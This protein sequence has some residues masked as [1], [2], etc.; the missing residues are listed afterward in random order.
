[1]SNPADMHAD[2]V[3]AQ[4][5]FVMPQKTKTAKVK[6]KAGGE[7]SYKYAD[8]SDVI[9]SIRAILAENGFAFVQSVSSENGL[10]GVQTRLLH[11]SGESIEGAVLFLPAG[12]TP[13]EAGAAITYARRYSLTALLGIAAD[14]DTDAPGVSRRKASASEPSGAESSAVDSDP[15][16]VSPEGVSTETGPAPSG[17][18][19]T[20]KAS[21]CT[22]KT[23]TDDWVAS[24]QIDGQPRCSLCGTP[25][26]RYREAV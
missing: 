13:Q 15:A 17:H 7:Y 26:V 16:E 9:D 11:R 23:P 1:M 18:H 3:K 5:A 21:D 25:A 8:L 19:F 22:H 12:N 20:V 10:V 14:E 24:V 6:M 2:L 4:Q